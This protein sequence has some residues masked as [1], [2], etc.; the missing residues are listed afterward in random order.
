MW[1]AP[2]ASAL[3]LTGRAAQTI[4]VVGL[5]VVAVVAA[6]PAAHAQKSPTAQAAVARAYEDLAAN[7]LAEAAA[8]MEIAVRFEPRFALGWYLLGSI[9]RRTGGPDREAAGYR[10]YIE[11]RPSEPDA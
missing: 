5:V 2:A 9:S 8:E 3:R 10:R 7:K 4:L 11:L 1:P 6:P